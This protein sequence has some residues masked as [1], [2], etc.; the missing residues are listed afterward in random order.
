MKKEVKFIQIKFFGK[1]FVIYCFG[2]DSLA[3]LS[4]EKF[5]FT[6]KG[7]KVDNCIEKGDK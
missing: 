6:I 2:R 1:V 5:T 3:N 4:G 7:E